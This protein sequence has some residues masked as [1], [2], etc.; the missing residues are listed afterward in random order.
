M[1]YIAIVDDDNTHAKYLKMLLLQCLDGNIENDISLYKDGI[2]LIEKQNIN[3][4]INLDII[5][6]D[7]DLGQIDGIKMP[8]KYV[9]WDT[10]T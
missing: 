2:S 4:I 10:E 7:T 3:K 1:L 8:K 9:L 6:I 5:F